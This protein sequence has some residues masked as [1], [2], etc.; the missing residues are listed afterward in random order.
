M[1]S[2]DGRGAPHH[3]GRVYRLTWHTPDADH[4]RTRGQTVTLAPWEYLFASFNSDN[5][6][7]I[8]HPTWIASL[9]LLVDPDRPVQRPDAGAPSP[10]HLPRD[11]GVAVVDRADH[12]QPADHRVA[13][14]LRLLHRPAR[15][16][17]S[18]SARWSGS[19]SSASR[20]CSPPTSRRWRAS[21]TS[22]SRSIADPE[23]TIKK[24]PVRR[25]AE[26][27]PAAPPPLAGRSRDADRDPP[28]R[29]RSPSPGRSDR[30]GRPVRPGPPHRWARGRVRAGLRPRRADRAAREP[31]HDPVHRRR[32]R[33]L[34]RR[35]R[36]VDPDRGR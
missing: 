33:R 28:V 19:A 15:P 9:V 35:R 14:R 17:S 25:P 8:F 7:D 34:G 24:R 4:T 21:A 20:R 5:F 36:R 23:A 6:P 1:G 32:G 18:A 22:R 3:S 27:A 12:V 31:E 13:V 26:P 29:G 11:V 16:R 2:P 10:R 30:L